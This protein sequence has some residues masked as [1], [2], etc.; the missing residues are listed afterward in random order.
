M[1]KKACNHER[2]NSAIAGAV[3]AHWSRPENQSSINRSYGRMNQQDDGREPNEH[4]I[5]GLKRPACAV[6]LR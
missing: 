2:I 6:V 4:A 1:G 3:H 5:L